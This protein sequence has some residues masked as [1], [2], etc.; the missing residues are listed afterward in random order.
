MVTKAHARLG[1]ED[2]EIE[3]HS[4]HSKIAKIDISTT[5]PHLS[6]KQAIDRAP[7]ESSVQQGSLGHPAMHLSSDPPIRRSVSA[8]PLFG[9]DG[10]SRSGATPGLAVLLGRSKSLIDTEGRTG[11]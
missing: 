2:T 4:D 6:I 11:S 10:E 8:G 3:V 5:G 1:H 9:D 7:L